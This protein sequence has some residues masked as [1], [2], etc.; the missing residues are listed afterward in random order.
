MRDLRDRTETEV[1]VKSVAIDPGLSAKQFTRQS[2]ATVS[3]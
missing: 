3:R 2:L 1:V